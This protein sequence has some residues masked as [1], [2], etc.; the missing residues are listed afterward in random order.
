[1][2]N[3]GYNKYGN[4]FE[5][6]NAISYEEKSSVCSKELW[7]KLNVGSGE[8]VSGIY[9]EEGNQQRL[10]EFLYMNPEVE[11]RGVIRDKNGNINYICQLSCKL[12][13]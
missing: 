9:G 6:K 10:E 2:G 13:H 1:V 5:F 11:K 4:I 3:L 8:S 12:D 7:I